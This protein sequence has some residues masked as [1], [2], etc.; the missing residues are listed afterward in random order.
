MFNKT[1]TVQSETVKT[2]CDVPFA[3]KDEAKEK[4]CNWDM[5][6]KLW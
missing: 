3:R 2:Y 4:I 6:K 5:D 1:K